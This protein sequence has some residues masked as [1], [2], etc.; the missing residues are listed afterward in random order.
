VSESHIKQVFRS[1]RRAFS[2][3]IALVVVVWLVTIVR[4]A[5]Q[6]SVRLPDGSALRVVKV[7]YGDTDGFYRGSETLSKAAE[8]VSERMPFY[9]DSPPFLRHYFE[10]L[11]S[12]TGSEYRA[13]GDTLGLWVLREPG[14]PGALELR[15]AEL[16]DD[17]TGE[18]VEFSSFNNMGTNGLPGHLAFSVL[19][20]RQR[21]LSIRILAGDHTRLLTIK[22]PLAGKQFP[23]WQA[24]PLPQSRRIDEIEVVMT[25]WES[26]G[27]GT[28]ENQLNHFPLLDFRVGGEVRNDWF[29]FCGWSMED[30]TGNSGTRLPLS[31]SAWK[32]STSIFRSADHPDVLAQ[33]DTIPDSPI[34]G[35][36]NFVEIPL[37]EALRKRGFV[38][39]V[40]HGRGQ[41]WFAD[42][43]CVA[44]GLMEDQ[45]PKPQ[46]PPRLW[47]YNSVFGPSL[48]LVAA[49]ASAA[50]KTIT[51]RIE[52]QEGRRIGRAYFS[53]E[54]SDPGFSIRKEQFKP[55]S[56]SRSIRATV[57]EPGKEYFVEFIAPPPR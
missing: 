47:S 29:G 25:G 40:V 27:D 19:P 20:R 22:N 43:R 15:G 41:F 39:A 17:I 53:G 55:L 10:E 11:T 34:P 33:S 8:F 37:T 2:I 1:C 9:Y 44:S 7:H 12:Y 4:T 3:G 54:N 36:G 30:A 13:G 5:L 56:D 16:L 28:A 50:A 24:A 18:R 49:P 46:V 32:F 6:P 35:P 23:I 52:D 14:S 26:F 38:Y 57:G 42:G 31:E 21:T 45:M 51:L 48:L